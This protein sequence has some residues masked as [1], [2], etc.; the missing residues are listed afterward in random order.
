MI[1]FMGA[2]GCMSVAKDLLTGMG[3]PK[4]KLGKNDTRSDFCDL[5]RYP[6]IDLFDELDTLTVTFYPSILI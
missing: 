6:Y 3:G 5:K 4:L 1:K 2:Q